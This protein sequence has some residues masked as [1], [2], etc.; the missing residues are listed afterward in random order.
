MHTYLI[1]LGSNLGDRKSY[2]EQ[3]IQAIASQCGKVQARA[4]LEESAPLGDAADQV[5]INTALICE[6][7]MGP[8]AMLKSL[9]SIEKDLGRVRAER[10]GNRTI[11]LDIILWKDD[12]EAKVY[13]DDQLI[14]PHPEAL[15]RAFV[16][17]PARAIAGDWQH[18][19]DGRTLAEVW[20]AFPRT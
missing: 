18:P 8:R 11:D 20:A 4:P 10:W 17:G 1:A 2:I 13:Q 7:E 12:Q 16:L 19:G 15:K 6:S 5:F 14:I 9:L 3:A